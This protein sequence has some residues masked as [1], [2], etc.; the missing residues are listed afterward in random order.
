MKT[1]M[2]DRD[3]VIWLDDELMQ[4][5]DAQLHFMTHSLH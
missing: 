3:G 5:R 2:H 4:W 1:S